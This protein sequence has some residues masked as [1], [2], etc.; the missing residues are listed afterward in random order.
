M[1]RNENYAGKPLQLSPRESEVMQWT[2]CGKTSADISKLL[3]ITVPTVNAHIR[4]AC[5]KLG[6]VNKIHA[7]A[8]AITHGV[9]QAGPSSKL[10]IPLQ[11][12]FGLSRK[13]SDPHGT[14][15]KTNPSQHRQKFQKGS[16][17]G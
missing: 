1:T 9:I 2:A 14:T 11:T 7:T 4:S 15:N 6:A 12:L 17:H 3:F 5:L 16:G 8:I 10:I 13:P